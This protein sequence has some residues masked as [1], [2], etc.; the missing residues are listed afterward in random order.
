MFRVIIITQ[1]INT[2]VL[3]PCSKFGCLVGQDN[4]PKTP[5]NTLWNHQNYYEI[6]TELPVTKLLYLK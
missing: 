1:T 4:E 2:N 5:Q 6:N 3:H